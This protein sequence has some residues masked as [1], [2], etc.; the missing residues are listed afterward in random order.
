MR[1]NLRHSAATL[2][3]FLPEFRRDVDRNHTRLENF[4]NSSYSSH[5]KNF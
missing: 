5:E 1:G 2:L 3:V 4:D